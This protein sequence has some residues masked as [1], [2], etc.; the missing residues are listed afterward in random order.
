MSEKEYCCPVGA[1]ID[2]IGGMEASDFMSI[3]G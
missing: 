3:K 1:A 2:E